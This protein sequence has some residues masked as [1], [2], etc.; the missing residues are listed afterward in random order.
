M[1]K[2]NIVN[3]LDTELTCYP[4]N[5]FP[6]G[7]VQEIIEVGLA[8]VDL[9]SLT[10]VDCASIPV[11]PVMSQ[12]S[13]Y[14]TELTGWT[15]ARL[16][17]QGVP[18]AEACRR[19]VDKHGSRGRLVVVDSPGDLGFFRSE[20]NLLGVPYPFGASM[21]VSTL[22][23]VLTQ[24][25][26]RGLEKKLRLLGLAFE[27]LRH[28]AD[29]DA[30]NI[31]R[32]FIELVKRARLSTAISDDESVLQQTSSVSCAVPRAGDAP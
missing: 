10:I 14:C 20:C 5:V 22:F 17:R 31:A 11:V 21:N 26:N 23:T 12:M 25:R 6:E 29:A 15:A 2:S 18:F 27:G 24:R 32:L 9:R 3:V 4:G 13:D 1:S 16:N 19:L 8:T 28:R 7:Q 30:R